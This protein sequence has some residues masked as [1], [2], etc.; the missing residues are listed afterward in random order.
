MAGASVG[1]RLLSRIAGC[2]DALQVRAGPSVQQQ[3]AGS[4]QQAA[5][6]SKQAAGS[7]QAAGSSQQPEGSRYAGRQA[8]DVDIYVPYNA[9]MVALW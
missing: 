5:D 4:T 1:F 9:F 6:S 3:A 2:E 8:G 7:M